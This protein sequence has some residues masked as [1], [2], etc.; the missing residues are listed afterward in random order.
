MARSF[1]FL[2]VALLGL[3]ALSLVSLSDHAAPLSAVFGS[4]YA[5]MPTG[6]K[7][8]S[9]PAQQDVSSSVSFQLESGE[10][11][12]EGEGEGEGKGEEEGG[13]P[14][15]KERTIILVILLVLVVLSV[16]FE[17]VKDKIEES[18]EEE[19]EPIV[20]HMW[21]ELTI[22][23]FLSLLS[24][25]A[26]KVGL[27]DKI[28]EQLYPEAEKE[29]LKETVENVHMALFLVMVVFIVE[30]VMLLNLAKV[31]SRE[32]KA[33]EKTMKNPLRIYEEYQA[34]ASRPKSFVS[35]VIPVLDPHRSVRYKMTYLLMRAEFMKPREG[36]NILPQ[37]F[38]FSE[39]L[40]INL[41]ETV[42][43][44]VEVPVHIWLFFALF[45]VGIWGI[46]FVHEKIYTIMFVCWGWI[47]LA[48]TVVMFFKIHSIFDKLT[49]TPE[50]TT[51][52]TWMR[53][54]GLDPQKNRQNGN[55][56]RPPYLNNPPH[57]R[58]ALGRLFFGS[59]P[60]AHQ[61]LF[62]FDKKGVHFMVN[63]FCVLLLMIAL[64]IS[65]LSLHF[66]K[67]MY[68]TFPLWAFIVM[69]SLS[70]LPIVLVAF[71]YTPSIIRRMSVVCN[72][73][74]MKNYEVIAKVI[75][76]QKTRRTLRILKVLN[77][78]K[79]RSKKMSRRKEGQ[80]KT[81][82]SEK[83]RDEFHEIFQAFDKDGSGSIDVAEISNLITAIGMHLP[84]EEMAELIA[85]I[86]QNKD[87]TIC[88]DEFCDFIAE[89]EDS[90]ESIEEMCE[91]MFSVFDRDMS[92]SITRDEFKDVLSAL[93][94][95]LSADDVDGIVDA[96]DRDG[97]GV[98]DLEEFTELVKRVMKEDK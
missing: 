28:A 47:L 91:S 95:Q 6:R 75:R 27:I 38:D 20:T 4:R 39:Y 49:V 33:I 15:F 62:F 63:F 25:I 44:I 31:F 93:G 10:G 94:E 60:N 48:A 50:V 56:L 41:G 45:F 24:F 98:V 73:E 80:P 21:Q 35:H 54:T 17:I 89:Q 92:G 5:D 46:T 76:W 13:P 51:D 88:F 68:N 65:I 66:G 96:V 30:V 32:W 83:K 77:L 8:Q 7:L 79:V 55:K 67:V 42:G 86:D 78:M 69:L 1:P 52:H 37:D 16:A 18:T 26:V 90:N 19:L 9:V 57:K 29:E 81:V 3:V 58:S 97:D 71:Y 87:G 14:N 74:R 11:E 53:A 22:L 34:V 36:T 82:L 40:T 23:G 64:Y 85:E 70:I 72:I 84:P 12:K 2:T 43:E 59:P 61:Q